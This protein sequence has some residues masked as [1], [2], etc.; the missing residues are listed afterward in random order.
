[1][2]T[3]HRR[4]EGQRTIVV[5]YDALGADPETVLA[6]LVERLADA[7]VRVDALDA[8]RLGYSHAHVLGRP[9]PT[10]LDDAG[11]MRAIRTVDRAAWTPT[12][13]AAVAPHVAL[14]EAELSERYREYVAP[15]GWSPP[16]P[17]PSEL[18]L[19]APRGD[20]DAPAL[21]S[22]E[23]IVDD[24]ERAEELLVGIFHLEVLQRDRHPA[25]DAE[26]VLL[27]A[28]TVT[29][30]LLHP[31]DVGDRPPFPVADSRL[32]HITFALEDRTQFE[33]L[34]SRLVDAGVAVAHGGPNLFHL[35]EPFVQAVFGNSPVF[36]VV[37]VADSDGTSEP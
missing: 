27:S 3:D 12:V 11:R 33:E 14:V 18:T 7:G 10:L 17:A 15:A 9:R 31:T 28:G 37:H 8:S 35:P 20:S 32:A 30:S 2:G 21:V 24:L 13:H 34:R 4:G 36:A 5:S 19:V 29:L 1:M 16:S 25:F 6:S 23:F 22:A 26:I